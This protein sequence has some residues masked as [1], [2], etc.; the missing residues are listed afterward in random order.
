M[1]HI[2][3]VLRRAMP[4]YCFLMTLY[5]WF[6]LSNAEIAGAYMLATAGWL[7]ALGMELRND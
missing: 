3:H 2:M 6:H 7:N 5:F 4:I 1:E